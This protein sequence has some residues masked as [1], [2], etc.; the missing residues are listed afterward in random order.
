[1]FLGKKKIGIKKQQLKFRRKKCFAI[2]VS[3]LRK[4]ALI[5]PLNDFEFFFKK[6]IIKKLKTFKK[7]N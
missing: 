2:L 1:M 3:D 4:N 6:K 5:G 7:K